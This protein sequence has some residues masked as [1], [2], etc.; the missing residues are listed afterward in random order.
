MSQDLLDI[1]LEQTAS[2]FT[3]S[4]CR[5]LEDAVQKLDPAPE[6]RYRFL[7]AILQQRWVTGPLRQQWLRFPDWARGGEQSFGL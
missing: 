2:L 3:S 7:G 5:H 4:L 1:D 6:Q